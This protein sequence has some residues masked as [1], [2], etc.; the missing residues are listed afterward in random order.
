MRAGDDTDTVA[1]IAGAL[2]GALWGATAV[3]AEWRQ[4]VHGWPGLHADDLT[5][6]ALSTAGV[7]RPT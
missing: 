7:G 5:D 2:A 1:A 4:A 3:P 6:L